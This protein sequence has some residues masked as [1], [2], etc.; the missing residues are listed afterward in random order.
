[1]HKLFKFIDNKTDTFVLY[2]L[3]LWLYHMGLVYAGQ[4]F[5]DYAGAAP[6]SPEHVNFFY[7]SCTSQSSKPDTNTVTALQMTVNEHCEALRVA[8]FTEISC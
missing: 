1:M 5:I 6:C 3:D 8:E 2:P 7:L 4:S